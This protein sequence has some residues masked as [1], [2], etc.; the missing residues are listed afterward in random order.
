[1]LRLSAQR[2]VLDRSES[3]LWRYSNRWTGANQ[4]TSHVFT[5]CIKG[6]VAT[7]NTRVQNDCRA[8]AHSKR[9]FTRLVPKRFLRHDGTRPATKQSKH[10]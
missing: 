6:V 3:R 1:M 5:A 2:S 7:R 9:H 4:S 8:E 10:E